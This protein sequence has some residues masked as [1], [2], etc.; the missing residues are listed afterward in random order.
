MNS[1]H[2][3]DGSLN[4]TTNSG[5]FPL[6]RYLICE[7]PLKKLEDEQT[8]FEHLNL[9]RIYDHQSLLSRTRKPSRRI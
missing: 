5:L 2:S 9:D 1:Q 7:Q 3:L 4:E 6:W 8:K